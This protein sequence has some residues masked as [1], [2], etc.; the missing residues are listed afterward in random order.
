MPLNLAVSYLADGNGNSGRMDLWLAISYGCDDGS[1]H[2]LGADCDLAAFAYIA[3]RVA[4]TAGHDEN[5]D[6]L[7]LLCPVAVVQIVKVARQTLVEGCMAMQG[8]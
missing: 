4:A 1:L 5:L 6:R 3:S 2:N 8:Q 7:A